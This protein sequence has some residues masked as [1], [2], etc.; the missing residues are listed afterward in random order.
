MKQRIIGRVKEQRILEALYRSD[1]S[2]FVAVYGRR[3]VGKTFLVHECFDGQFVFEVAGLANSNTVQ[4]LENF[5]NALQRFGG[6]QP[7][8]KNWQEAFEA[9]IKYILGS[10]KKRKLI[11]FDELPWMDTP[12]SNFISALEGFWNGWASGRHDIMLVVCGS[13]TS[14]ITNNLI[15]NH[16]GLHNR[17]TRQIYLRPF[18]LAESQSFLL[19]RNIVL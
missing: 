13:A 16:G 8:F 9:L 17:L 18:S 6:A 1:S 10:R 11:F 15:N 3:R 12:K 7:Q 5:R 2:E 4:Q 19:K 14:W